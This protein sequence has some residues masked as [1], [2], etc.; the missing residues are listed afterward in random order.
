MTF[1]MLRHTNAARCQESFH[2]INDWSPSDWS[3]AMAGETGEA[4]NITKKMLRLLTSKKQASR[5]S[6][7][8]TEELKYKLGLEIADVVIYADLLATRV[9]LKLEDCIKEKFN[10][11]SAEVGSIFRLVGE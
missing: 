3:N 9:G 1:E 11:K 10:Q 4:C 2:P 6:E 8:D 7:T 5:N